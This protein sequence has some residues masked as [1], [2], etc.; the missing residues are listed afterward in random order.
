MFERYTEKARRV[1]FFARYEAS[2]FGA[3]QI[4]AEHLLLGLFREDKNL[5]ARFLNRA[6]TD[7][8][9]IRKEIESRTGPRQRISTSVDLL[10]SEESKRVLAFAAEESERLSHRHIGTEHLLLGLLR[11]ENSIA[12]VILY[13]RGLRLS[14]VRSELI[15]LKEESDAWRRLHKRRDDDLEKILASLELE[16]QTGHRAAERDETWLYDVA[17]ACEEA[18]LITSEELVE[19]FRRVAA[20]RQFRA[21]AE[22]LLRLLAAKGLADPH[23]LVALAFELRRE[24]RLKEFIARLQRKP[25]SD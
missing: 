17:E 6:N 19:E 8:E 21:D 13:E 11:E 22:A 3:A 15:H 7:V 5:T 12:S 10:L 24:S 9:T 4:E 14:D 1:I 25:E 20:L 16:E 2:Q 23:R 18:G